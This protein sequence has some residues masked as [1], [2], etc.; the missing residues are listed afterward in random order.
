MNA[1]TIA[2]LPGVRRNVRLAPL[3][4]Y[5]IGGPADWFLAVQSAT[6]LE[7]AIDAARADNVPY[8]VLGTGANIIVSDQGIRGLVIHNQASRTVFHG[9]ELTAESG[10]TIESLIRLTRDRSLSGL[11]HFA[12]I[13]SSVGGAM[14]QNLHFLN[15]E[16]T[17]TYYIASIVKAA[18]VLNQAGER[19]T[20]DQKYF[21]FGYDD[22]ILHHQMV[23]VLDVTFQLT[24]STP[25]AI[26]HQIHENLA[27]RN[28]K[29]PQLS[30]Y[31]SCGSVFKKIEG[32]GA[33]RLI[34]QAGLKGYI[35]GH[36]Q[37]SP[38]HANYL[39]NLGGATATEVMELIRH[40]QTTV[41][42]KTGHQLEPEVGIVG[43]W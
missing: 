13:P 19:Q 29:Q 20:V 40:I 36:V 1:P 28:A 7:A 33:G 5:Q 21:R 25:T 23:I 26:D 9:N 17:G 38:K 12:G 34:D 22:S 14:R 6:E 32:A 27:W 43:E 11:E 24:S 41:K 16:R 39:V 2:N 8:F 15:P 42:E 35:Y 3:T 30:E 37:V 4:T 18:T 31:A 10:A